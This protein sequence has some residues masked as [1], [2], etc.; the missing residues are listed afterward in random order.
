M[1]LIV[2]DDLAIRTSLMLLLKK[3][4]FEVRG[5]GS[6]E[7]TFEILKVVT[8]ELILL[9]LNFSIITGWGTIDLAV[10]GMKEGAADFVTKPWQNDYL[11]QSIRTILNLAKPV[12]QAG[13]RRKLDQQYH[14]ENIVGQDPKLLDILETV[15]RVASYGRARADYGREWH[16]KRTDR[17]SDPFEQQAESEAVCESEP[18]RHF[19]H[20]VRKRIVRA[21]AGRIYGC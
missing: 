18:G 1:L 5:A 19:F 3:E 12:Q 16:R 21:C 10:R 6:P 4:G 8:P 13:S 9:D 14:F 2:D 15:G 20:I 17:G 11:I 7:E